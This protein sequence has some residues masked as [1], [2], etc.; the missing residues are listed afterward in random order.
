MRV[1]DFLKI[2]YF[3]SKKNVSLNFQTQENNVDI[4]IFEENNYTKI[5]VEDFYTIN[6]YVEKN[7]TK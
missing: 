5:I 4:K 2:L 3:K 7:A 6:E 1:V